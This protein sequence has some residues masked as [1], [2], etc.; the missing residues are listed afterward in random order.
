[1][2]TLALSLLLAV[3]SAFVLPPKVFAVARVPVAHI[4]MAVEDVAASC[5]EE[6]CAK[7]YPNARAL[8][9]KIRL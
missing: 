5:L 1:M 4:Q 8:R 2:R 3:G 9:D 6:G 7:R